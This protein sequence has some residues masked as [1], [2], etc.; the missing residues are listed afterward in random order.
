MTEEECQILS[1]LLLK[2]SFDEQSTSKT[3]N[4]AYEMHVLAQKKMADLR[5]ERIMKWTKEENTK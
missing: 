3:R 5:T 2:W 1:I 4:N